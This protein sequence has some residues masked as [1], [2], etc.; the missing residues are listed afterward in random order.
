MVVS[1]L[2]YRLFLTNQK[3]MYVYKKVDKVTGIPYNTIHTHVQHT[4]VKVWPPRV[5]GVT[6]YDVVF[7]IFY[8]VTRSHIMTDK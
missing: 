6:H 7:C 2:I 8:I 3:C 1:V 4:V 5:S